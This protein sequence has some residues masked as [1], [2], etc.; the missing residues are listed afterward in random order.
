MTASVISTRTSRQ[1]SHHRVRVLWA[2]EVDD[3]NETLLDD[4]K[5]STSYLTACTFNEERAVAKQLLESLILSV[6]HLAT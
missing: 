6:D 3:C 4:F 2:V 5:T 1:E